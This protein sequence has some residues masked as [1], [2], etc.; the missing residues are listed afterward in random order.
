ML[1]DKA[2]ELSLAEK[3]DSSVRALLEGDDASFK[4]A[5]EEDDWHYCKKPQTRPTTRSSLTGFK[6]SYY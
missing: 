5:M 1:V 6:N 2:T 4:S 3:T